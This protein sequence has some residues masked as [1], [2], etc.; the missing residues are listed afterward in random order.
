MS[1]SIALAICHH[2]SDRYTP[3]LIVRE[4]DLHRE[5]VGPILPGL[6]VFSQSRAKSYAF[7]GADQQA[8][9]PINLLKEFS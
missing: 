4:R 7:E 5:D 1:E 3:N 9:V 2:T 8:G 6:T